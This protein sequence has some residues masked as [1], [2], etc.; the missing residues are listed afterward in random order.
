VPLSP[1]E[2]F[3]FFKK[4]TKR[5][6]KCWKAKIEQKKDIPPEK[7]TPSEFTE[8][9]LIMALCPL[10]L[11]TNA[12]SGHFHFLMLLPPAEPDANEYSVG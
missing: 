4:N 8:S 1:V 6:Q 3:L 7:N 11:K 10:Q 9:V 5:G 2:I 12:P